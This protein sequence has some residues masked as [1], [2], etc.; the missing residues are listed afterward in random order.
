MCMGT[1]GWKKDDLDKPE[2]EA[3]TFMLMKN[4]LMAYSYGNRLECN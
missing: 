3:V 1:R 2:A 4:E